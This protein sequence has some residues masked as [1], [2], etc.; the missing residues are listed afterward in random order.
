MEKINNFFDGIAAPLNG[1]ADWLLRLGLGIAFFLHGFGK[2]PIS[3]WFV[4]GL[5]SNGVLMAKTTV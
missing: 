3:E 5:C 1:I 2:F 4:G